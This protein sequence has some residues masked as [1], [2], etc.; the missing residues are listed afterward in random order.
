MS[1]NG[2]SALAEVTEAIVVSGNPVLLG[3][4]GLGSLELVGDRLALIASPNVQR[5]E[6][7]RLE[8][9]RN[10]MQ[11]RG[12]GALVKISMPLLEVSGDFFYLGENASLKS[13]DRFGSLVSVGAGFTIL[14]MSQLQL[15]DGF[16]VLD[17]VGAD[18]EISGNALPPTCDA[19]ALQMQLSSIGGLSEVLGN[20]PDTCGG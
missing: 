4:D 14:N 15:P 8:Q 5:I 11:I 2:F 13:I 19:Q 17:S 6:M 20:L 10:G 7:A 16:P 12:H 1:I 9:V 18:F 3:V